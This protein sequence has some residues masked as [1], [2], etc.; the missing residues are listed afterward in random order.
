MTDEKRVNLR[1][2]IGKNLRRIREEAG[3]TIQ[4]ASKKMELSP[5]TLSNYELG[6]R[7]M[8]VID[9]ITFCNIYQAEYSEILDFEVTIKKER[10]P[11][12]YSKL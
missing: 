2:I 12:D 6:K 4:Q 5:T 11:I 9:F 1:K 8:G 3:D 10:K 7:E